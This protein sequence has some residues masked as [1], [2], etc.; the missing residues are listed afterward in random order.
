LS[1]LLNKEK[2][3]NQILLIED[4]N[5]KNKIK[6]KNI[7]INSNGEIDEKTLKSSLLYLNSIGDIIYFPSIF[8]NYIFL[9]Q[10][11]DFFFKKK[12]FNLNEK[13][14]NFFFKIYDKKYF[15]IFGFNS[16]LLENE[17]YKKNFKN[18]YLKK[19]KKIEK[20]KI[21]ILGEENVGKTSLKKSI[22]NKNTSNNETS[23]IGIDIDQY[24]PNKNKIINSKKNLIFNIYD[25]GL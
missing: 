5:F 17:N 2:T 12:D 8:Q 20:M 9:N 13:I 16:T 14:F 7:F 25:F 10:K 11:I 4:E 15:Q 22:I 19:K 18:F 6:K 1:D 21:I 24:N 23:T 3:K